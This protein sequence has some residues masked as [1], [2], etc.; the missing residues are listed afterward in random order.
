MY[1]KIFLTFA[2]YTRIKINEKYSEYHFIHIIEISDIL[3]LYIYMYCIFTQH[4]HS[5]T[6][7]TPTHTQYII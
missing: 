4:T 2:D 7:H 6:T 3:H 1:I 5:H